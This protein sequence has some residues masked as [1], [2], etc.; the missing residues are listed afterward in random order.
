ML[1]ILL[2]LII[3]Y[4][5]YVGRIDVEQS[6]MGYTSKR[7]HPTGRIPLNGGHS[8]QNLPQMGEV[9]PNKGEK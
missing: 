4:F 6:L 1:I 8:C 5:S 7:E 3:L 9:L 2:S